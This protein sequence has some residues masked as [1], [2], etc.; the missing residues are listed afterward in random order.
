MIV[1]VT[2]HP[3]PITP[4]LCSEKENIYIYVYH[5]MCKILC[6]YNLPKKKKDCHHVYCNSIT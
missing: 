3:V 5:F 6:T 4:L 2:T 1:T